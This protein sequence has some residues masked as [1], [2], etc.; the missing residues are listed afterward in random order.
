MNV[1]GPEQS[2]PKYFTQALKSESFKTCQLRLL[3][4][5]WCRNEHA[6][7]MRALFWIDEACFRYKLFDGQMTRQDILDLK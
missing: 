3:A 4:D 6:N 7:A 5:V 1:S 2:L